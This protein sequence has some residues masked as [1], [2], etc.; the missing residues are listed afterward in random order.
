M[1][2]FVLQ[3]D[4]DPNF[5]APE[6]LVNEH[7]GYF[8]ARESSVVFGVAQANE[9]GQSVGRTVVVDLPS[10]QEAEAFIHN[11]PYFKAGKTKAIKITSG[12]IVQQRK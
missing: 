6:A 8:A 10:R 4:D 1:P 2:L 7:R 12:R 5:P 11:E 3:W 9:A